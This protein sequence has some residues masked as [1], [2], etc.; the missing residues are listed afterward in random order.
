MGFAA[1]PTVLLDGAAPFATGNEPS[2]RACRSF[3]TPD[4]TQGSPTLAQLRDVLT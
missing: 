1:S 2:G 4:G 3:G